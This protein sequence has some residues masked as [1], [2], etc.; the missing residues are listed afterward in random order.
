MWLLPC[1]IKTAWWISLRVYGSNVCC[2][3]GFGRFRLFSLWNISHGFKKLSLHVSSAGR[4]VAVPGGCFGASSTGTGKLNP[5]FS[6]DSFTFFYPCSLQCCVNVRQ[7]SFK[8][9]LPCFKQGVSVS[10]SSR[11]VVGYLKPGV[12]PWGFVLLICEDKR[13]SKGQMHFSPLTVSCKSFFPN[14]SLSSLTGMWTLRMCDVCVCVEG[15]SSKQITWILSEPLIILY[16]KISRFG[17]VLHV[18]YPS[19]TLD[20]ELI[21]VLDS[22]ICL[23]AD[24][25]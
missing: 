24:S 19:K 2:G 5:D 17:P 1:G 7:G 14:E 3:L 11:C 21:Y 18:H 23:M 9:Q 8:K 4:R 20:L 13:Y 10:L 22:Q 15:F 16:S 12:C 25:P 6:C